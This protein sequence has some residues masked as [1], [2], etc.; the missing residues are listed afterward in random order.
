M[1][2]D[3]CISPHRVGESVKLHLKL[4]GDI[5]DQSG[6]APNIRVVPLVPVDKGLLQCDA[7]NGRPATAETNIVLVVEEVGCVTGIKI[8]SLESFMC[9]QG[10]AGPFPKASEIAL[11]T[12]PV[13]VPGH[14]H[15]M[16]VAE[17]DIAVL[18][19][20]E[21]IVRVGFRSLCTTIDHSLRQMG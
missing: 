15:R 11:S 18:K 7:W 10:C 3:S 16:P 20:D 6:R 1:E 21:Q 5:P 13:T 19:F 4:D 2:A 17:S 9:C 12:E 8:H 14:R